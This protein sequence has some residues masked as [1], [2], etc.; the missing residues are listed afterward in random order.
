MVIFLSAY[1]TD[2]YPVLA[3]GRHFHIRSPDRNTISSS[4]LSMEIQGSGVMEFKLMSFLIP[5]NEVMRCVITK[6][7]SQP[8][9]SKVINQSGLF[10][11]IYPQ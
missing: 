9:Y 2:K 6:M 4:N 5:Y 3:K 1:K 11:K 7:K 8:F 10:S